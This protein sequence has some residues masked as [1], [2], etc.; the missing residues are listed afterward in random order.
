M[1]KRVDHITINVTDIEK[2]RHF[3]CDLLGFQE[4]RPMVDCGDHRYYYF[5]LPGG[6]ALEAATYDQADSTLDNSTATGKWRH[7]AFEVDD[8]M[9]LQQRLEDAGYAFITDVAYRGDEFGF[10]SG[11]VSDPDGIEVEFLQY[12]RK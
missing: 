9:G 7:V 10:I 8:I 5:E 2:T 12:S 3:Y 4:H 11:Q 6:T 1:I